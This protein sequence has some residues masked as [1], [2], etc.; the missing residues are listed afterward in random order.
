M[1][2]IY[3]PSLAL[4]TRAA[5]KTLKTV[6]SSRHA[7]RAAGTGGHGVVYHSDFRIQPLPEGHRFPMPKDALLYQHLVSIG[8]AENTLTPTAPH[9]DTL[10]LVHQRSYVDAFLSGSIREEHMKRIGLP[11][12]PELVRRTLIGVGSAIKAARHAVEQNTITC[13]TNGGTHHAHRDHGSGWCIF[14]DQAIAAKYVQKHHGV[15][16]VLFVDLDVHQGDGTASI[17]FDDPSVYTFSIHC[18]EQSFPHQ[19]QQSNMDVALPS[20]CSD[21]EY[22]DALMPALKEILDTYQFDLVMY[23]AGVD[24]HADDSLGKMSLTDQGIERRDRY[25]LS[26]CA[27][28]GIPVA[29]AIGG[30]YAV[31]H[32][33]I[34]IRHAILH[35]VASQEYIKY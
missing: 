8:L 9:A 28:K 12:S 6:C 20:G 18:A 24:V 22:M 1:M 26:S 11:W 33:S 27:D 4:C 2:A 21:D 16:N 34:V 35:R 29:C 19:V 23:N 3:R 25:V 14:N 31:N 13:M 15:G 10:C 32:A 7:C 30:G 5:A 17:F